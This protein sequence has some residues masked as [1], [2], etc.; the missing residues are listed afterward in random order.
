MD[1]AKRAAATA[2]S[3]LIRDG[4]IVGFGTGSTTALVLEILAQKK[5]SISGV[6]TSSSAERT[7]RALGL[8]LASLDDI[9]IANDGRSIDV[10]LDGAD[11][12]WQAPDGGLHLIKGRG[13]AHTRERIIAAQSRR[14]V[15]L[16]D[17]SKVVETL[18][19]RMPVPVEII[20]M[21]EKTISHALEQ[22][23][24]SVSLREGSGKDGP[25]VSDQGF[26]ILDAR[27]A[28]I[29]DPATL[30]CAIRDIP[31]VLDH[32]LFVGMADA[33]YIGDDDGGVEVL[34]AHSS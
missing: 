34:S 27:F 8:S 17:R 21:A 18:G 30:A 31:G 26:W 13:A 2:A 20:P 1:T 12:V 7:A 24:A 4:M 25:I 22:L 3:G 15:V 5:L 28:A 9:P 23:G 14:F 16:A 33:A 10:G 19:T 29:P 6:P 11:E 32:G